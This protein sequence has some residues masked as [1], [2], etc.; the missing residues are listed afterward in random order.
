MVLAFLGIFLFFVPGPN[1]FFFYPAIRT[2]GHYFA[3]NGARNALELRHV[4]YQT[5]PLIDQVQSLR[6]DLE[7]ASETV[8]ELQ[9]RYRLRDLSPVLA[10]LGEK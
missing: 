2:L 9:E 5:E 1:V 6:E 4:A 7:R 3:R 8:L 10:Q